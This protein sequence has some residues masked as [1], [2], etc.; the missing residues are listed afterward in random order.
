M[1]FNIILFDDFETLDIFGPVEIFGRNKD[2]KIHYYSLNGGKIIS[3][4]KMEISTMPMRQIQSHGILVIPG[5]I[6]TR[7]LVTDTTFLQTLKDTVM[8]SKYCLSICTGSALFAKSGVL[9]G[10]KATSN[11][12]ALDWVMTN[13]SAVLWQKKARW[14]VDGKFYTASGVSAGIDMALGFISD[15]YGIETARQYAHDIEYI[16]QEN[17]EQDF[18]AR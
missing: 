11:K 8:I 7:K 17:R 3:A 14:V 13:S 4:Q 16:W 9:N 5:G 15:L 10:K 12:K 18:F 6:G 1:T 2:H